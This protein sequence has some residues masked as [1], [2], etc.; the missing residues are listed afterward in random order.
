[1]T[2]LKD[3]NMNSVGISLVLEM[4]M[5]VQRPPGS[6]SSPVLSAGSFP[7]CLLDLSQQVGSNGA[8]ES[9]QRGF[10]DVHTS[11]TEFGWKS[12]VSCS[13]FIV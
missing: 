12:G 7:P 13:F 5:R 2:P 8:T 1:M 3:K 9:D 4:Q 11:E 6:V 10:M